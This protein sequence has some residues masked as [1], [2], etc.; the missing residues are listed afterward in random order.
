MNVMPEPNERLTSVGRPI[1]RP[2]ALSI[3]KQ[4]MESAEQQRDETAAREAGAVDDTSRD[5][6]I[7]RLRAEIR[8]LRARVADFESLYLPPSRAHLVQPALSAADGWAVVEP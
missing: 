6:E 1:T 4:T 5:A 7:A 2:E 8:K 3:A